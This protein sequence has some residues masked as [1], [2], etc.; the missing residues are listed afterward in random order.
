MIEKIQYPTLLQHGRLFNG[1]CCIDTGQSA[2]KRYCN[3]HRDVVSFT[4]CFG[5]L[6]LSEAAAS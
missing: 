3:F 4:E 2:L 1:F 5:I 6:F